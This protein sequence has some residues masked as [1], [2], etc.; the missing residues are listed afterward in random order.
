MK[1]GDID[2]FLSGE[3]V[4]GIGVPLPSVVVVNV[5]SNPLLGD[6]ERLGMS[7]T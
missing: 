5:L 6:C 7:N 3:P 1:L 2:L 4:A